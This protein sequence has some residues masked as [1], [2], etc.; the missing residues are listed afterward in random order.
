M[1]QWQL[2]VL[3][4]E[5]FYWTKNHIDMKT[6]QNLYGIKAATY[7]YKCKSDIKEDINNI[8]AEIRIDS[9]NFL[10]IVINIKY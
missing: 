4:L 10:P 7:Y 9:Y 5:I 1:I 3:I 2:K 8:F 6:L